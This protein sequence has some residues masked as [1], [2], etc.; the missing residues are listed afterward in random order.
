MDEETLMRVLAEKMADKLLEGAIDL[1][2]QYREEKP[3][4]E[5]EVKA[6][7]KFIGWLEAQRAG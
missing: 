5:P 2:K 6:L 1:A 4:T 7:L 3:L